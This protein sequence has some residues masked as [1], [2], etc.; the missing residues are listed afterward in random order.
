[1]LCRWQPLGQLLL[2]LLARV[3]RWDCDVNHVLCLFLGIC[4]S[5]SAV[6]SFRNFLQL[7]S[8]LISPVWF[9]MLCSFAQ[10]LFCIK[11]AIASYQFLYM[12]TL[13]CGK[14]W[15]FAY[16][17]A[18]WILFTLC[19]ECIHIEQY[20]PVYMW[21]SCCDRHIKYL[22]FLDTVYTTHDFLL[23][24]FE[25]T[26]NKWTFSN[27]VVCMLAVWSFHTSTAWCECIIAICLCTVCCILLVHV[28]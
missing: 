13:R 20:K 26:R 2:L 3:S 23:V 4:F 7:V 14:R 25:N 15:I 17:K 12:T 10:L 19:V 22:V 16:I 5:V 27:I 6:H 11:D 24:C 8:F 9:V 18:V 21:K 1:M 28:R